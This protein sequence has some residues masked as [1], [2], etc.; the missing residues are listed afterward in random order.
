MTATAGAEAPLYA[1]CYDISN[2]RERRQVDRLLSGYGYRRQRSV[3]ECR[4]SPAARKRMQAQLERLAIST[5]H[6]L[7]Y[8]VAVGGRPETVGQPPPNPDDVHCYTL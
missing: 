3:F 7:L 6:V 8:R 4:L 2:D 5:G 1:V